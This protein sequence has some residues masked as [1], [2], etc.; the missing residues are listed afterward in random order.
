LILALAGLQLKQ[1]LCAA[2]H[3]LNDMLLCSSSSGSG[4]WFG[5][6]TCA[7][8]PL[9]SICAAAAEG[10]PVPA[11][12]NHFCTQLLCEVT[13]CKVQSCPPRLSVTHAGQQSD[14]SWRAYQCASAININLYSI[15]ARTTIMLRGRCDQY[16]EAQKAARFLPKLARSTRLK[17]FRTHTPELQ[18]L[19]GATAACMHE[20][21][22]VRSLLLHSQLPQQ[23]CK[24]LK[25]ALQQLSASTVASLVNSGAAL[26]AV[27]TLASTT[28]LLPEAAAGELCKEKFV[29][30]AKDSGEQQC[31][32]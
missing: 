2:P 13:L 15:L 5:W 9:S 26:A 30:A 20:P 27:A 32:N 23:L 24:C 6:F 3:A 10:L 18:A 21:A 1:L 12:L 29:A 17:E 14:R 25:V 28:V 16:D 11:V 22:V 7:F 8:D 19:H 4:R 31:C